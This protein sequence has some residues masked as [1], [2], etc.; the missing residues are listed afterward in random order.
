[1]YK[2]QPQDIAKA[3]LYAL[4]N[5]ALEAGDREQVVICNQALQGDTDAILVCKLVIE[6]ALAQYALGEER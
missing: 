3:A 4:K 5:E 2:T 1:M 6:E